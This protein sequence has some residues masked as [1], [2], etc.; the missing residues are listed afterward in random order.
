MHFYTYVT[1][2][3]TSYELTNGVKRMCEMMGN[4]AVFWEQWLFRNLPVEGFLVSQWSSLSRV[5]MPSYCCSSSD[6]LQSHY[7]VLLYSVLLPFFHAPINV[8]VHFPVFLRSFRF[9]SFLSQ[10]SPSVTQIK[11]FCSDPGFFLQTMFAKDSLAVWVTA[12]L[13]VVIIESRSLSSLFMMVGGANFPPIIAWKVSNSLGAFSF[14]RSNLCFVYFCFLILFRRRL[15]SSSA[16]RG[17]FQCLLP[18]TFVF[19]YCSL[20]IGS[21]SSL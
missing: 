13:K 7:T 12:V 6:F 19:W 16:I 3:R 2:H 18:E 11:N 10:F 5:G 8:V 4:V 17:Y 15:K 20:L 14:S 9:K 21:A 1:N